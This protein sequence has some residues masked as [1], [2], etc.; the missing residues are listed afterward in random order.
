M[1][2]SPH[3]RLDRLEPGETLTATE[4]EHLEACPRCRVERRLLGGFFAEPDLPE[5]ELSAANTLLDGVRSRLSMSMQMGT[6]ADVDRAIAGVEP[7]LVPTPAERYRID[8]RLGAGGMGEVLAVHDR[9]LSRRVAMKVASPELQANRRAMGRFVEEAQVG[10]QLQHPG[11]VPVHELGRLPDGRAYFTMKE[12][13]GITLAEAIAGVQVASRA[14]R[15]SPSPTGWTLRRLVDAVRR[16]AETVAYAHSRGVVHRD[17]KPANIMLG[18]W[19]EVLVVDWGLAKVR[20]EARDPIASP[21]LL[22]DDLATRLGSV[23]GTPGYMAPEQARGAQDLIGPPADVY[24]LGAILRT[25]LTGRPPYVGVHAGDL[26]AQVLAGP[27][28]AMEGPAPLPPELVETAQAAMARALDD[29][30]Q[31]A[32]AFAQRVGDWLDGAARRDKALDALR[33]AEQLAPLATRARSRAEA[34]DAE[35]KAHLSVLRSFDSDTRKAAG[36]AMED[37]AAALRAEGEMLE[38]RFTEGVRSALVHDPELPEAHRALADHYRA[39]HEDAERNGHSDEAARLAVLLANHDDGAHG[40]YLRG[41]GWVSLDS[42]EPVEVALFRFA[43]VAR[44]Q[45]PVLDRTVSTPLE[46]VELP[47][48]SWMAVVGGSGEDGST[49]EL[50]LPFVVRRDQHWQHRDVLPPRSDECFVCGGWYR[51]GGDAGT[52]SSLP[53]RSIWVDDFVLARDPVTHAEYLTFLNALVAEGRRDEALRYAPRER[54]ARPGEP[55]ALLV[56]Y[57]AGDGFALRADAEGDQWDPRW[58][59]WMVDWSGARA[60]AAWRAEATGLPWRL[61]WEYEWEKACRGVDGRPW[62]WGDFADPTW[63]C[64]SGSRDGRP[65]PAPVG[66]HPLDVS[67]YGVR[68][69]AGNV[70]DWTLDVFSEEGTPVGPDGRFDSSQPVE[71]PD[72]RSRC[73][74]GGS[75]SNAVLHG[76]G[77]FRDGRH[78]GDRRWV[79]GFRLARSV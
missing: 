1:S 34:L 42:A 73:V 28:A 21:R 41:V 46:R 4:R 37:E 22:D 31:G 49:E 66:D 6:L 24:A 75:W 16:V 54:P 9:T 64:V 52:P 55:G 10:A 35:A 50:R 20:G 44:R 25:V 56:A 15:W 69:L 57:E 78:P 32:G 63:A 53:D 30:L 48:G 27:P 65:M 19:G 43:T 17:L 29:R 61:P 67:V 33:E 23:A 79:I 2:G 26:L 39:Q 76:R 77:A 47:I 74:K 8:G 68:G 45:V 72:D 58:P 11:V 7:D 40:D 13:D 38:L 12:V 14:G 36:W 60:Y 5:A 62:P 71:E 18:S 59:A 3:L 51:S 70:C